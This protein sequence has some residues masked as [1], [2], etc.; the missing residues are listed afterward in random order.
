MVRTLNKDLLGNLLRGI[1]QQSFIGILPSNIA[2]LETIQLKWNEEDNHE[3][4]I[5]KIHKEIFL[6]FNVNVYTL[7]SV[8]MIL[9]LLADLTDG[10]V[11]GDDAVVDA[12]KQNR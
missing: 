9:L 3:V 12:V 7:Y 1:Y 4:N 2:S 11:G 5:Y 10:V 6:K 8:C